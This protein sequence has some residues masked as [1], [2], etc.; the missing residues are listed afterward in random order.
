MNPNL[1]LQEKTY[2]ENENS[3]W[4]AGVKHKHA[5]ADLTLTLTLTP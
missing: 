4:C 5:G 2:M 1:T 3:A